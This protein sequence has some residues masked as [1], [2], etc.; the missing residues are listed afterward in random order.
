MVSVWKELRYLFKRFVLIANVLPALLGFIMA[1]RYYNISFGNYWLDFMLLLAGSTLLVAGAL[2]LNN[3]LEA[4][5]DKLMERTKQRP[6]VTGSI[7]LRAILILGISLSLVGQLLL[8]FINIEVAIL[9]FIGW[10]TYVVVYTVWT[11]RRVTWNT[12]IGSLSGAVTPMMGWAVV[13]SAFHAIPLTLFAIMFL[14][15]MPHTYAI[16]IRKYD[17]YARSGLK[18]LPVV[19][20]YQITIRRNVIYMALLLFIPLFLT[21]FS[22]LFYILISLLNLGWLAIGMA[23]FKAHSIKKWANLLFASSLIYLLAVYLLYIVFVP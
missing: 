18:M 1:A 23:G 7:S 6:T 15:Q 17:D 4:D 10:Y 5:V 11:K 20:G 2:T 13:G 21:G 3:W 14:W 19:R 16:A 9:G 22:N 12:H 8:L